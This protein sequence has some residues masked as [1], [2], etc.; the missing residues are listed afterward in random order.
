MRRPTQHGFTLVELLVVIAI[1]GILVAMLLPAVQAAR[2][3]ARRIQ[4]TNNLKQI[5][6]ALQNYHSANGKFPAAASVGIPTQCI[7]TDC[8]GNPIYVSLLPFMEEIALDELYD[9]NA[10]WG[11][12][13][14]GNAPARAMPVPTYRCPSE[15]VWAQF[16]VRRVYFAVTGGKTLAAHNFRGDVFIDGIFSLN[17]WRSIKDV[18]DGTSHTM[19]VGESVH[20]SK[21]GLGSGYGDPDVGGPVGWWHGGDC[22]PPNC[23]TTS[24]VLGRGF[25]GTKYPINSSILPMGDDD[26]NDPPFGSYHPGGAHFVFAD[27]HVELIDDSIDMSLYQALSTRKD[28]DEVSPR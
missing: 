17:Q 15:G 26:E 13:A 4:C 21:F 9:E 5:G 10:V 8:R 7:S 25:R 28:G 20:V 2:E 1:I 27:G 6:L 22:D 11:W 23:A 16:E 18:R 14:S 3:A 19:A 12:L 24:H